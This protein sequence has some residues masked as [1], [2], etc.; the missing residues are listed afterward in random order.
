MHR[1]VLFAALCSAM[2]CRAAACADS[3]SDLSVRTLAAS[4]AACHGTD[5]QAVRASAMPPLAGLSQEYF[6]QQMQ[7]YREGTRPAPLMQQ[8]ARGFDAAQTEALAV[9]FERQRLAP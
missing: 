3:A 5:G 6:L 7:A 9:Y 1:R 8:I 2:L 4:C